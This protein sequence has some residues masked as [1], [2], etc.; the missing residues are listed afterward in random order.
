MAVTPADIAVELGR[1]TPGV[2]TPEYAQ[3]QSWIDRAYRAI[4]RRRERLGADEPP[5]ETV[6]DVVTLAVARKVLNPRGAESITEQV[7]VDDGN[8]QETARYRNAGVDITDEWWGWLFP[9]LVNNV[10]STQTYGEPD[11]VCPPEVWT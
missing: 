6:D 9:G 3:W 10:G 2:S 8:V 7:G 1:A 4:E 11:I 5:T